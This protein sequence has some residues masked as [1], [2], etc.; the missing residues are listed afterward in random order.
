MLLLFKSNEYLQSTFNNNVKK[1]NFL[2]LL[3]NMKY[4]G[5]GPWS[6]NSCPSAPQMHSSILSGP[7]EMQPDIKTADALSNDDF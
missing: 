1:H 3:T 7:H 4:I 5:F 6:P 2:K